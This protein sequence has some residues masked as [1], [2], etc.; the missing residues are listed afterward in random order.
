MSFTPWPFQIECLNSVL[1]YFVENS[2][3]HPLCALPTGTGK[4]TTIAMLIDYIL[5]YWPNQRILQLVHTKELVQQNYNDLLKI[6]PLAPAGIYCAGL[7]RKESAN[8]VIFGSLGSVR[9][10][11]EAF[12]YRDIIIIDECFSPDTEILTENGFIR[13]DCLNEEKVAQYDAETKFIDFC[14]PINKIKKIATEG[15]LH[16]TTENN[17]DVLLTPKHDL[18]INGKKVKAENAISAN[19]NKI[20]VAGFGKGNETVLLP[21]EKFAICYQAD[22]SLHCANDNGTSILAFSFSK[23]RKIKKF[24]E[25]MNETGYKFKEVSG[26][27]EGKV[28][29]KPRRRFMVY[30]E[31]VPD[32][33][34]DYYF[35]L[36]NLSH[37]KAKAIIEYCNLWDGHVATKNTYLYTTTN[38]RMAN[39]Y[40]A[41]SILAGCKTKLVKVEDE[42]SETFSDCYRLF[43]NI[44]NDEVS[45]QKWKKENIKYDGFVYCVEVPKGNIITRRNGKV[46][47]TGNCHSVSPDDETGYRQIISKLL[48]INPY[49]RVVGF[50]ATDYRLGQ[51][52]LTDDDENRLF[53][54]VCFDITKLHSFNRLIAEGYLAPLVIPSQ[55]KTQLDVSDVPITK[56]EFNQGKLQKAVDKQEITYAAI[57]EAMQYGYNRHCWLVFASGIDHCEHIAE[58]LQSFGIAASFVHSKISDDERDERLAEFKEGK[59][60]AIVGFRILTT[61]FNHPPIDLIIDLYPTVSPVMHVQKNGRGTRTYNGNNANFPYVKQNC[62]VLDFSGNTKRIGPVND[63]I[64]PKKKG[65]E[66]GEAPIKIC[67]AKLENGQICGLYNHA[68]A[69]YCGGKPYPTNEGCGA[70]FIFKTK[71]TKTAGS[72][73]LIRGDYAEA[74][75]ESFDVTR[76]IYHKHQKTGGKP[77]IKISYYCGLQRHTEYVHPEAIGQVRTRFKS[78]WQQRHSSEPPA[79]VDEAL[80]YSSQL[81]CPRKIHVRTDLQYHEIQGV[82]W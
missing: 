9:N 13:F 46:I 24:L 42:R 53:T 4:G 32:K 65:K 49:L 69:R 29:V 79:T 66:T 43:I 44:N 62:L 77:C 59:L 2:T 25:L 34:I 47:I 57:Q 39:F 48:E 70:E 37:S 14:K 52:K 30:L 35:K 58:M 51:G 38:L 11:I 41:V 64:I 22:G 81:R 73:V 3:G 36:Q 76:V 19:Y 45:T 33:T 18:L 54:D 28:N 31:G 1:N 55:L 61:G 27:D 20:K 80:I 40:Q 72:N 21:W 16:I 68:S 5:Y 10:N 78:W 26:K 12:G 8:S 6:N 15:L 74:V 75:I 17:F 71:L 63:P 7:D 50:T 56:G 67:E 82:E 23:E 60:K